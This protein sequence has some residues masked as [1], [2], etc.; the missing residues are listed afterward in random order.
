ML[1]YSFVDLGSDSLYEHL[2][3]CIKNDIMSGKLKYGDKLPSKR[4]F[5]KNL[6]IST[7]TVENAYAQLMAEGYIYSLPKKGYFVSEV[8]TLSEIKPETAE[9]FIEPVAEDSC[10][11]DFISNRTG[12]DNFPFS[13]WAK[14][15]REVLSGESSTLL[16]PPPAGGLMALRKAIAGHL[17][18]FRGIGVSPEQI[19]IGAGTEYLYGMLIQLFGREAV[20]A[21]EDP[22]YQKIAQIYKSHDVQLRYI[23]MDEGGV[24]TEVLEASGA[25][26][27]HLSPS[28]HYPTGIVTPIS[29]RYELLGWASKDEGRYII[30]DD[31]DSEFRLMGRP[32][33]TL[34]SI[35]VMEKVIYMNTFSKSLSPTIR[36]S[37]MV[38]PK[39][40]LEQFR[41]KLGFYSCTVSNFE[42]YTLARFISGGYFE[43]HINRMRNY[44]RNQRDM[45]LES[46]RKSPISERI[47]I[48]E[49]NS[50]LHFLMVIDTELSDEALEAAAAAKGVR[51]ACLSKYYHHPEEARE[52]VVVLNYSGTQQERMDEA[53]HILSQCA[54]GLE[55]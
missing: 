54:A 30:E 43:K 47:K 49:E 31:Y 33:P 17:Y 10:F 50:G 22:G 51:I 28:H 3:K 4:S 20:Y 44:Y 15:T 16:V 12:H 14:L 45:L 9:T 11:A 37:Y 26:I 55:N 13:I 29:R 18:Q 36:I 6:D 38:L 53:I 7:I 21:I 2:Y 27:L 19:I 5:A 25:N 8:K 52:H 42:Q 34:Q 41:K 24:R 40:L 48:K 35:D 32:I 23:P 1:T 46:I 39:K